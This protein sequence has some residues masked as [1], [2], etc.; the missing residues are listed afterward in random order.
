[1]AKVSGIFE[2]FDKIDQ[3]SIEDIAGWLGPQP[4]HLIENTL[5]NRHLYPQTAPIKKEDLAVELAILR[6]II[7]LH[8]NQFLN[9]KE[10]KIQIPTDFINRFPDLSQLTLALIDGLNPKGIVEITLAGGEVLGSFVKIEF[11][12]ATGSPANFEMFIKETKY[13]FEKGGLT[14]VPCSRHSHI[15]FKSQNGKIDGKSEAVLEIKGGRLG[16]VIDGRERG[17]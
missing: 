12:E 5:A 1:M 15:N 3:I 8:P 9:V 16:L 2:Q 11:N 13:S 14:V 7:R 17:K 10:K 4:A 6:E